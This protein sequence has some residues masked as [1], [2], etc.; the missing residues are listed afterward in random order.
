MF[1][2]YNEYEVQYSLYNSYNDR[3]QLATCTCTITQ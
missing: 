1:T 2:I 3:Y